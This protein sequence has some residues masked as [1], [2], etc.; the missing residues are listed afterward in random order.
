MKIYI[1]K[2]KMIASVVGFK[3]E[4]LTENWITLFVTYHPDT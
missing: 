4:L 1:L 3:P 2:Q